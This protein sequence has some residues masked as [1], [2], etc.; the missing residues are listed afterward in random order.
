MSGWCS[1]LSRVPHTHKVTSS[2]LVPDIPFFWRREF[3]PGGC[4]QI[5]KVCVSLIFGPV[6]LEPKRATSTLGDGKFDRC[7]FLLTS[8]GHK[9]LQKGA[10]Y[11]GIREYKGWQKELFEPRIELGTFSVLD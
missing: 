10:G 5:A 9:G 2:I 3:V 11:T 7:S 6:A 4:Y 1:W 8:G